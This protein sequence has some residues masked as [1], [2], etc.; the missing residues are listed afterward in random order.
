[1]YGFDI[2]FNSFF[3]NQFNN[4]GQNNL[5]NNLFEQMGNGY[6]FPEDHQPQQRRDNKPPPASKR[7]ISNLP[8][9][10]ITADDLIE[11]TNKECL[12]CLESHVIGMMSSKLPCG[13]LFH[14]P[15]LAEWLVKQCTCPVCRYELETEDVQFEASRKQR[16][17][18]R[19][20]RFRKDELK[21]HSIH[22]LK[23][24]CGKLSISTADCLDKQE[25][26]E[27][28]I[29]SGK[30]IVTDGIPPIEMTEEDF[31]AKNV[32]ELKH[33]LLAFG[34]S[35]EGALEKSDLRNRLL[36]SGRIVL[37]AASSSSTNGTMEIDEGSKS[38]PSKSADTAAQLKGGSKGLGDSENYISYSREEL[39]NMSLSGLREL[40]RRY[41][42]DITT[43]LD[44]SE[45]IEAMI[46][47]RNFP[48]KP[49]STIESH[50]YKGSS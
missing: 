2:M 50:S 37:G 8:V 39:R 22:Q 46:R 23:E 42:I 34:L 20:L 27:K 12:I 35:S 41:Q 11:E 25:I 14:K 16:M 1:M 47:A 9:V 13:H 48:V 38:I 26:V 24:L 30:V 43:C 49:D 19:K 21:N 10:Q 4:I 36:E 40:C 5:F 29:R 6:A 18:D 32:S 7:A 3:Q 17:K 45:V 28:I 31:H 33:L 44:K 15:C